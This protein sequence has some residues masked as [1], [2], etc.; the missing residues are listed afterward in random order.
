MLHPVTET[1]VAHTHTQIKHK[2]PHTHALT[3]ILSHT[4][5]PSH[6]PSSGVSHCADLD[7]LAN[8][9]PLGRLSYEYEIAIAGSHSDNTLAIILSRLYG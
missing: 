5:F 7:P 9:R 6:F 4:I 1:Y 8:V 3:Q 2:R